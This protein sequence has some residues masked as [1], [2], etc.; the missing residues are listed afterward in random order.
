MKIV[1]GV[2]IA[3]MTVEGYDYYPH[4]F[5]IYSDMPVE[6]HI[7][8]ESAAGCGQVITAPNIRITE[9]LPRDDVKVI[10]FTADSVGEIPFSCTM[11]MMT[12]GAKFIVIENPDNRQSSTR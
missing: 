4:Q 5:T 9:F 6:W 11:G 3:E 2:Q 8:G 10:E 7:N 12:P 1:D